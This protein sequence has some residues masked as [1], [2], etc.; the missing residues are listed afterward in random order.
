[1]PSMTEEM[2][3]SKALEKGLDRLNVEYWL[4]VR[5]YLS[6]N[7]ALQL[8]MWELMLSFM[9][10]YAD[11]YVNGLVEPRDSTYRMCYLSY[12]MLGV[13]RNEAVR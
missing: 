1:M 13:L 7:G 9:N 6:R 4:V 8:N 11:R 2:K 10:A 5:H 12:K 3:L